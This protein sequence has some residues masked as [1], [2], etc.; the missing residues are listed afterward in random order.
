[1]AVFVYSSRWCRST[2]IQSY[3]DDIK[4]LSI[5][6]LIDTIFRKRSTRLTITEN[7]YYYEPSDDYKKFV[8]RFKKIR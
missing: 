2:T 7:K 4:C 1:M 8:V 5:N 6:K 3:S